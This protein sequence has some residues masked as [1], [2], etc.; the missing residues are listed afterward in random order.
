M[1]TELITLIAGILAGVGGIIL[2]VAVKGKALG[3]PDGNSRRPSFI[4][5]NLRPMG[6]F[7][8]PDGKTFYHAYCIGP[9]IL[10]PIGCYRSAGADKNEIVSGHRASAIEIISLYLRWG[11]VV[12]AVAAISIIF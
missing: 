11:W 10:F 5:R 7:S 2:R 6:A 12:A 1:S 8:H 4:H 9:L 3:N